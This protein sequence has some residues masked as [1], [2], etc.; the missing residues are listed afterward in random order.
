MK[1]DNLKNAHILIV[2][3]QEANVILLERLL[4]KAGYTN[5]VSTSDPRQVLPLYTK[6]QP[7]LI[8][9]DLMMPHLDGYAVMQQIGPRIP[10]GAFLPI[11]VLTAE[12]NAEA[13]QK[14]LSMGAKDFLTKPLDA[15]EV[16]LRIKNL[17]ETR[18]L[19][20]RW[21]NQNQILEEKVR[22]KTRE[23]EDARIEIL[24][25]LAWAS[26]YRE[27]PTGE[28][29]KRVGETSAALARATGLPKAQA[30][31]IGLA[32]TLHDV[33]KLAVPDAILNKPGKVTSAEFEQIKTH[34]AIGAKILSGTQ[35]PLLQMAEEIALYHHEH[36]DGS[37]Y[38]G[39]PGPAIPVAA[40]IVA[41]ADAFDALTHDRPYRA[42]MPVRDALAE[43]E[44]QSGRQFE[45]RLVEAFVK[46]HKRKV[47]PKKMVET[48]L[49]G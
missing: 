5:L 34:T 7:D 24:Q 9:L 36:W 32:A 20:D 49:A 15:V 35:V 30:E 13:R 3:D 18:Q 25:R 12:M 22:E 10:E 11:L 17:L 33:G 43:L 4:Q 41:V 27:D 40:R 38:A 29:A 44:Q 19:H 47:L 48:I 46:W 16:M 2:D 39:I 26:E 42:A 6:F 45:P 21:Q 14:A 37:G 1:D 31:L 8:L 23:L 28:H